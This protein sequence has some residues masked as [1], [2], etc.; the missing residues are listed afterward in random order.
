VTV[1]EQGTTRP[2]LIAAGSLVRLELSATSTDVAR[3][4]E[5]EIPSGDAVLVIELV[6]AG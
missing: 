3:S 6:V 5:I 4:N 2:S 1:V